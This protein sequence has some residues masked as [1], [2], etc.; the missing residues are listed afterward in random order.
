MRRFKAELQQ[1]LKLSSTRKRN[2]RAVAHLSYLIL[3]CS[4]SH[5]VG[6]FSLK[7]VG[8]EPK[9]QDLSEYVG[10]WEHKVPFIS[11][12]SKLLLV[13]FSYLSKHHCHPSSC[14][15]QKSGSHP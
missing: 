1:P 2:Q 6:L 4:P 11:F 15:S 7:E 9:G 13:A 8:E 12:L 5:A 14:L 10:F 3:V